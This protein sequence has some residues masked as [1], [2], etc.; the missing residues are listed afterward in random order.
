MSFPDRASAARLAPNI[1]RIEKDRLF[2]WAWDERLGEM[3][4]LEIAR[5]CTLIDCR[6]GRE[7]PGVDMAMWLSA[8]AM[9]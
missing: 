6:T 7:I 3:R 5:I 2:V 1:L 9:Q 4:Q 8:P